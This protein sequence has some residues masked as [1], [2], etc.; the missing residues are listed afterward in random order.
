MRTKMRGKLRAEEAERPHWVL[1]L[2][3]A[4]ETKANP[5][6]NKE[7]SKGCPQERSLWFEAEISTQAGGTGP[8]EKGV[9]VL[10]K[11]ATEPSRRLSWV[12]EKLG[13]R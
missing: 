7:D 11:G 12:P 2:L 8:G 1:W 10:P 9:R 13:S 5:E 6:E 4:P 3:Q